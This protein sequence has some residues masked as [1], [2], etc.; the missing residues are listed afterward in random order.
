VTD[1]QPCLVVDQDW[2]VV[3]QVFVISHGV[4]RF[5]RGDPAFE[6]CSVIAMP[7]GPTRAAYRILNVRRLDRT[8]A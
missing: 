2:I 6:I 1:D 7:S 3:R 5:Q 4:E 8:C